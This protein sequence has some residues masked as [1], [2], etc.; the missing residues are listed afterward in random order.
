LSARMA[1]VSSCNSENCELLLILDCLVAL[2]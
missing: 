1:S 2:I